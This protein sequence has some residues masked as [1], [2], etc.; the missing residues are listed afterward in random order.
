[1]APTMPLPSATPTPPQVGQTPGL[2]SAPAAEA[3]K[4][5][6]KQETKE[7]KTED[8]P[9]STDGKGAQTQGSSAQ[10]KTAPQSA[11]ATSR[12]LGTVSRVLSLELFSKPQLYQMNPFVEQN[13]SQQFPRELVVNQ[14]LL[15]EMLGIKKID[16][17]EKFNDLIPMG[18]EF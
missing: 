6:P 9:T 11:R 4:P 7:N 13:I 17:S 3:P 10:S 5:E 1:M 12:A 2:P 15:M 18:I 16:Q 8:K 14:D